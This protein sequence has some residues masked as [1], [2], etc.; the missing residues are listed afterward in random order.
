MQFSKMHG[1]GNDYV[2]VQTFTQPAPPDPSSLARAVS[3]RHRGIGADGLILIHPPTDPAASARMEMYNADG[4]RGAMCGNG[5]RCVAK[6]VVDRGPAGRATDLAI[7]TDAGL[8][9][10]RVEAGPVPAVSLA[11]VDMGPPLL[12]A[13]QI[14]TTLPADQRGWVVDH[15]I[16]QQVAYLHSPDTEHHDSWARRSGFDFLA[17]CVSMGNPHVVFYCGD[18]Q[19]VPLE[20]IG[21]VLEHASVFPQRVNVHV[22]QVHSE[23]EVTMRTWERGSGITQA[24]GTGASAVCVAGLL[25]GATGPSI[26]AHLPGGDLQLEWS[27]RPEDSVF[28]TG[29]AQHVFDGV[30]PG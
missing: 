10:I 17:T 24:C 29:P 15:D 13:G 19:A 16:R 22:V 4:S 25:T 20:T 9:H 6:L 8:K 1:L 28:M 21:V 30:W 26:L 23:K 14:P 2:Y 18:V 3:D 12:A 27:G 5:I 7:Q 11:R